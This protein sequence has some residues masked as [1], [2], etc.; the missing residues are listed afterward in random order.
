MVDICNRL[1]GI[2]F[3]IDVLDLFSFQA[4]MVRRVKAYLKS[5]K[6]STLIND[7]KNEEDE[8]DIDKTGYD[9]DLKR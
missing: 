5:M 8:K 9:D 6:V 2:P 1:P 7:E 3:I 4:Q